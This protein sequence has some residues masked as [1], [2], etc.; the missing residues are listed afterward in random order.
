MLGRNA[1][2]PGGNAQPRE[3]SYRGRG[4]QI[5]QR[6]GDNGGGYRGGGNIVNRGGNQSG[7]RRDPNAIDVDRGRGGNRK[8]Y[9]CRKFGHMAQNCWERN[10]VRI[11]DTLQELAKEN[12]GQ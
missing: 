8:C 10:K 1:T 3:G 11:V 9:Q 6:W 4:G 5:M 7:P 12:G 2:H